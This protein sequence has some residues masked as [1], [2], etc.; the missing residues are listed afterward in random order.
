MAIHGTITCPKCSQRLE[1]SLTMAPA[2]QTQKVLPV[3]G[4]ASTDELGE[5]LDLIDDGSLSGAAVNFVAETRARFAQYGAR[6]R[7]SEKQIAWLKKL[8]GAEDAD[9]WSA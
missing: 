7:V 5:L 3:N 9:E 2:S 6:T 4:N 1:V 8:A